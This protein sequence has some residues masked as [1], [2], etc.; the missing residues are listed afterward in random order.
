MEKI[1]SLYNMGL[2]EKLTIKDSQPV[3]ILRL[4]IYIFST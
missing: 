4:D 3:E 1:D 2:H